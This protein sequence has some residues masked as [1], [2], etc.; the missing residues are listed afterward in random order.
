MREVQSI[1][2]IG[3][4]SIC[5]FKYASPSH[6]ELP[7]VLKFSGGQTSGMLLFT[8]LEAGLLVAKRG[9]VVIFNNTSAEH[10]KTYEFT[11]LCKQLVENKYGIPFFWLEYQTYEDARSGEYTRLP[12]YRLVNTEPMSE[13]N[14][15][16]YHW[17]GEVYEELLSWIG[18][19]PTVFQCP[20]T[21]S[22]KLETTR[23][24]LKEWFANKP[25]TKRLG[26][27]GKSSRLEDDELYER[28][29]RN[30][31]GVPRD[32]FFEKKQFARARP[33]YRPAQ[34]YS[35]FSF[36]ARRFQSL[37]IDENVFGESVIFGED[38]V[39]YLSFVG[40]RSDEPHRAAKVRQRNSGGPESAGYHGEHAYMPLFD[41]GI[42]KEDVEDFWEK[43]RWRLELASGDGLSN[44]V[45]CFLKGLKVLRSAHAALG[46]V[47][48][49]ELQNTPC[50]LNWWVN[51]EQKYGRDMKAEEREMKREIP[52]DFIGFFGAN[53]AF[54]YQR[55]AESPRT[56]DSLAEF[57][58]SVLPCDCTD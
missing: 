35:D 28:H 12:S 18:F 19:V 56:K 6:H 31:G 36:P 48:D 51:L 40:L 2:A 5:D 21:Q 23:A 33:I 30:G 16:G 26:H 29:L 9:D 13:T 3:P 15:D 42:T 11:R 8:L 7:H 55:L 38:D 52:N 57:A 4:K 44:C 24:F 34:P 46:T 50:D 32:I 47:V 27:F 22:L 17:R 49:E 43:Q 14:P 20:C 41:M 10:P 45:F 53:S 25:E 37:Y 39:E 54:S 58:D 1:Q